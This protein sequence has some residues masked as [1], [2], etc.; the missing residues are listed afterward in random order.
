MSQIKRE[1][2]E[3]SKKLKITK[4]EQMAARA[5]IDELEQ[6]LDRTVEEAK[7][8]EQLVGNF[9]ARN[10]LNKTVRRRLPMLTDPKEVFWPIGRTAVLTPRRFAATLLRL[11]RVQKGHQQ[12][13]IVWR[14]YRACNGREWRLREATDAD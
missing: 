11:M 1:R 2:D 5:Q 14:N 6:A 10:T 8:L 13:R 7:R 3:L 9:F 12:A 4:I